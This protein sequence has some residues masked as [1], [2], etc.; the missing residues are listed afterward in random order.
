MQ[1]KFILVPIIFLY[2]NA[3]VAQNSLGSGNALDSNTSSLGTTNYSHSIPNGVRN[4]QIREGSLLQGRNF[5][6]GI[7][8][9]DDA[10]L[11]LLQDAAN[12]SD[13][14][15]AAALENSP[16]YWDN[17]SSQSTQFLKQDRSYFNP[18][19]IDNWSTL[20]QQMSEGRTLRSYSHEW[21]KKDAEKFGGQ[22]EL[23]YNNWSS[24]Q[25]DQHRLGE[26]LGSGYQSATID[27]SPLPV[28]EFNS[29]IT[30]GYLTASSLS[31]ISLETLQ[32]PTSALGFTAWDS[33]RVLEDNQEGLGM[34]TLINAWRTDESQLDYG[35]IENRIS[36]PDQYINLLDEIALRAQN[37]VDNDGFDTTTIE[38]LDEEYG[39]LQD[40]LA[41]LGTNDVFGEE[42]E[43]TE[44]DTEELEALATDEIFGSLR[45]GEHI[46]SFSGVENSRFN[47]LV[48]QGEA[49]LAKGEYFLSQK[50]FNRA[51]QFI[52][53]HPM[54]TSGL[55]HA[56]LGAGLYL[57]ASHI[58]HSLLSFQPEMIDVLYGPQLLP[59]RIELIR[60][61]VAA[62]N[63]LDSVRDGSTYAFL[64]A[65]IGHQIKDEEMLAL[66]LSELEKHADEKD[67]LVPMLLSIWGGDLV[68][69][70]QE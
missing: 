33:A 9:T 44:D 42:E 8:R 11:R 10:S 52:R 7:G 49:A 54:A 29:E 6:D 28:G 17:W 32:R 5:N 15:Y 3:A 34:N 4:S 62:K 41:G 2:S 61:G 56:N 12:D 1:Y 47:E 50:R 35:N 39:D 38:W 25:K 65:Y 40:E 51:L 57:S 64:L 37:A 69:I 66:G 13:T 14:S 24:L 31:G 18:T 46:N 58:L 43:D 30:R 23:S 68:P 19:F 26:V 59:P 22:G 63:R 60:A 27:A 16:W 21:N 55:A 67:R 45:H 48:Q 53:G 20:P 36:V 70:T